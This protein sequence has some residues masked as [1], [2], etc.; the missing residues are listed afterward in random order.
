MYKKIKILI[1]CFN[2]KVRYNFN[3]LSFKNVCAYIC[4]NLLYS[5]KKYFYVF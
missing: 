1:F 3:L 5:E 2:D 4:K